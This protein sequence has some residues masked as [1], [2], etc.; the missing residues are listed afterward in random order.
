MA[1]IL[2]NHV[3]E[4]GVELVDLFFFAL[5][6]AEPL[7]ARRHVAE[8]RVQLLDLLVVH[9][10]LARAAEQL[11][12]VADL[13]PQRQFFIGRA[14]D[15]E[16]TLWFE[17]GNAYELLG[18]ASEALVYYEKVE[19]LNPAFRDVATRIERLG[20]IKSEKEEVDEFDTMFEN[21]IVKD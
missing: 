11:V 15:E 4:H 9:E 5:D 16:L 13:E 8:G 18:R 3:L 10:G 12:G 19:E 20:V 21:M 7:D 6:D 2:H 14:P 17:I 1:S